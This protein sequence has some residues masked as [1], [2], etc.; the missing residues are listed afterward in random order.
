VVKKNPGAEGKAAVMHGSFTCAVK[1]TLL[2][3]VQLSR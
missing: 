3:L 2:I 1:L